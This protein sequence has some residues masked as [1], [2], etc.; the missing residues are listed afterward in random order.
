MGGYNETVPGDLL[1]T[2]EPVAV[3]SFRTW[4]GWRDCAAQD[5]AHR[6]RSTL[7]SPGG[8]LREGAEAGYLPVAV[9]PTGVEVPFFT[10]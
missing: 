5:P 7:W 1:R 10:E 2:H 3:A 8:G 6:Y 4:R 9:V